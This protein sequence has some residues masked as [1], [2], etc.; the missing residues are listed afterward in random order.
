MKLLY[1]YILFA[2]I[3]LLAIASCK[4]DEAELPAYLF[5]KD[6]QMKTLPAQG[7]PTHN[8]KD[9]WVYTSNDFLGVFDKQQ[10][11]PVILGDNKDTEVKLFAGIRENGIRQAVSQYF[12]YKEI[13][14]PNDRLIPGKIDSFVAIFQYVDHVEFVFIEDF[15]NGNIFNQDIDGNPGTNIKITTESPAFGTQCGV[16]NLNPEN[17][18][19]EVTTKQDYRNLPDKGNLVYL[20]MDYRCNNEFLVGI[21]GK[22]ITG[23]EYKSDFIILKE[24][25]EWNKIYLNFTEK[26]LNS[27]LESYRIYF[28]ARYNEKND[29][30]SIYLDNIKLLYSQK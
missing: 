28:K 27:G 8:I 11:I 5:V 1:I 15:E 2:G 25:E 12:L 10:L 14:I 23:E 30:T 19:I 22:D 4:D 16:I 13:T 17:D 7:A 26:I 18:Y 9:I 24:H 21:S 29:T 6:F 3:L 20:E